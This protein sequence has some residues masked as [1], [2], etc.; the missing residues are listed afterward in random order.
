MLAATASRLLHTR[1]ST[2]VNEMTKFS[3][4][5]HGFHHTNG[6]EH[7][8]LNQLG[9][10]YSRKV[11]LQLL[12]KIA[13]DWDEPILGLKQ[14]VEELYQGRLTRTARQVLATRLGIKGFVVHADNVGKI[15]VPRFNTGFRNQNH[16]LQACMV[17]VM[18]NRFPTAHLRYLG[19]T[20]LVNQIQKKSFH[21]QK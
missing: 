7:H 19:K 17:M 11:S 20:V 2:L 10:C 6:R 15:I 21:L 9:D 4:V 3:S 12:D 18:E 8:R 1:H 16:Y 14:E 5:F 13:E